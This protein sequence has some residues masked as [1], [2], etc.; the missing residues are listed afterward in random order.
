MLV[1]GIEITVKR[2]S[3]EG[4]LRKLWS[5]RR[6]GGA[7]PLRL[8]ADDPVL[9][10]CV[11]ALGTVDAAGPFRSVEAASLTSALERLAGRPRL[12]AVREPAAELDRLDQAG[13]PELRLRDLLTL[14]TL[15]VRLRNDASHWSRAKEATKSISRGDDW[16]PS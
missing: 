10:G 9:P 6:G 5:D 14:H 1:A 13:V 4:T 3:A 8:V 16:R 12:E 2:P 15:D 11:T 7:T